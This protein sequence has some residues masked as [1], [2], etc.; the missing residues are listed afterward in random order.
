[1][2]NNLIDKFRK[3]R[4][5]EASRRNSYY[6]L[7]EVSIEGIKDFRERYK[8]YVGYK[9]RSSYD[10]GFFYCPHIP[11]IISYKLTEGKRIKDLNKKIKD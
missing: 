9:G 3:R 7:H 8:S 11:L 4:E 2:E 6:T 5:E 10:A 1:M